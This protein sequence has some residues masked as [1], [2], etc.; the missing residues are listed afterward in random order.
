MDL[1]T[2]DSVQYVLRKIWKRFWYGKDKSKGWRLVWERVPSNYSPPRIYPA[3]STD[4][5]LI[6]YVLCE[7]FFEAVTEGKR[8]N[9]IKILNT[10]GPEVTTELSKS[11]NEHRETPL[12][13]AIKKANLNMVKYLVGKLDVPFRQIGR[14]LWRDVEYVD[15]PALYVAIVSGEMDIAAYLL[16]QEVNS[17]QT[18][19]I[20]ESITSSP[21]QRQEKINILELMGAFNFYF[22]DSH[23]SPQNGLV[24]WRAAMNLRHS[25]IDGEPTIPKTIVPSDLVGMNFGF[26]PEFITLEQLEQYTPLQ[27]FTQAI[28]V[29][30]RVLNVIN[31]G[32][33]QH[34]F[35][36][37]YLCQSA[38]VYFYREQQTQYAINILMFFLQQLEEPY[39]QEFKNNQIIS[40]ALGVMT[41][42][43]SSSQAEEPSVSNPEITSQEEFSNLMATFNFATNYM[44]VLQ[45][46]RQQNENEE[47]DCL[48]VLARYILEIIFSLNEMMPKLNPE[49][50]QQFKSSLAIFIRKDHRWDLTN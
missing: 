49:E 42:A 24:Y 25:I 14:F 8:K 41:E 40:W 16:S 31:P 1:P 35:T 47:P 12:M 20:V 7:A 3:P 39:L 13:V 37:T 6:K 43:M 9:L 15:V 32:G 4:P 34:Q 19:A 11:F 17:F 5:Q 10:H 2:S 44:S 21:N 28:L 50:S 36:L 33:Q 45:V 29:G 38:S 26:I 48:F 22:Y 18:A 23:P 27:L 46:N 30:Q